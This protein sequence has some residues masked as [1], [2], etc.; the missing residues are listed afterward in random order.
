MLIISGYGIQLKRLG[1]E[2]IELVRYW[3]NS[4]SI[5]KYMEFREEITSEMQLR[6]FKS[7]DNEKNFYFLITV[8]NDYIGLI[9]G[10]NTDWEEGI[11]HSGGIFIWDTRYI[12]SEIPFNASVLIT[13]VSFVFGLKKVMAKILSDN[14][15][16][17]DFNQKLGYTKLPDQENVYN[18][19]YELTPEKFRQATVKIR[20]ILEK[21]YTNSIHFKFLGPITS[22]EQFVLDKF[23]SDKWSGTN[24]TW[25]VG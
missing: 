3:R 21:K 1:I 2:D 23:K 19:L 15:R 18:Q 16:S 4:E 9:N 17:I 7:I 10:S 12:N 25:S 24:I 13:D 8:D 5:K 22:A 14:T 6:W 20:A 11:T